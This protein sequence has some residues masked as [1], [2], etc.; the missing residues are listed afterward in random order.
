MRRT[1]VTGCMLG[2]ADEG[3]AQRFANSIDCA[4]IIS[5]IELFVTGGS[6]DWVRSG[7]DTQAAKPCIACN[8]LVSSS[9]GSDVLMLV[10]KTQ[11]HDHHGQSLITT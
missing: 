7:L 8:G 2:D 6:S 11:S 5:P 1:I 10:A 9:H 3:T 4:C